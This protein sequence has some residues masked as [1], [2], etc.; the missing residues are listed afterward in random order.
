MEGKEIKS[1]SIP[2][3]YGDLTLICSCGHT[4]ILHSNVQ[5]GVN[6]YLFNNDE[7]YIELEC[8]E[9]KSNLSLKLRPALEP[10]IKD[11]IIEP[12]GE[13]DTPDCGCIVEAND[14]EE[15]EY[16]EDELSENSTE[17]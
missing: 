2:F 15:K 3:E 7:S 1:E 9:C 14:K 8:D 13:C 11:A 16:V 10:P 6:F 17:E 5:H 12:I 4:K